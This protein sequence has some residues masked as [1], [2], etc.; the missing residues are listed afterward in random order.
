[1]QLV[2][3]V[4]AFPAAKITWSRGSSIIESGT[5]GFTISQSGSTSTLTVTMSSSSR[6]GT[7]TCRA[8]NRL[9]DTFQEYVIRQKGKSP[10]ISQ[11]GSTW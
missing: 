9:G 8:V 10:L 3:T 11:E 4:D 6:R 7:Y 5:N 1:M 2:C